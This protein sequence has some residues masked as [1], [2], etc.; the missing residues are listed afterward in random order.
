VPRR[1]EAAAG[2]VV[3]ASPGGATAGAVG[4]AVPGSAPGGADRPISL[5][6]AT[7]EQLDTLDGIGPKLAVAIIAY[8]DR[9][10]GFKS[11]EELREVDGI[12][13]KRFTALREAVRP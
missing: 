6:T 7:P 10:R 3:A 11:I 4:A 1:G 2:A 5:S 12:G 13:E 8:R 9:H